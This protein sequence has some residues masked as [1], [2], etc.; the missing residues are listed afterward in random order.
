MRLQNL[1]SSMKPDLDQ[2]ATEEGR[3]DCPAVNWIW[4]AYIQTGCPDIFLCLCNTPNWIW[5]QHIGRPQTVV[6]EHGNNNS[7]SCLRIGNK[8]VFNTDWLCIRGPLTL[9]GQL[10]VHRHAAMSMLM[11]REAFADPTWVAFYP[12]TY[13]PQSSSS[14]SLRSIWGNF[15]RAV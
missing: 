5:K 10:G 11:V 13:P 14:T 9:V 3:S 12:P 7:Y 15:S 2:I 1:K 8:T 6:I 4:C